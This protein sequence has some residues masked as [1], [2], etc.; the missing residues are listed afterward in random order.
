M[1]L[2]SKS[3]GIQPSMFILFYFFAGAFLCDIVVLFYPWPQEI[4]EDTLFQTTRGRRKHPSGPYENPAPSR[5][6]VV[7]C[8]ESKP[9]AKTIDLCQNPLTK[10]GAGRAAGGTYQ[11]VDGATAA[12]TQD[13]DGQTHHLG[14]ANVPRRRGRWMDPSQ[15]SSNH[16]GHP[17][18]GPI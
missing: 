7:A 9:L 13:C 12:G 18:S 15:A 2:T 8:E 11:G 6:F 3:Q 14:V 10:A 5:G 1:I 16:R 4:Q 17:I